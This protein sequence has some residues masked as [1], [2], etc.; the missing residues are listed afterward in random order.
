MTQARAF[1]ANRPA[2]V[3]VAPFAIFLALTVAQGAF[4]DKAAYWLYA[5]KTALAIP[6]LWLV[7]PLVKELRWSFR[8]EAAAVGVGVFVLWVGLTPFYPRFGASDSVW[9]PFAAFGE[10]SGLAW[11]LIVVR[12]AGM[13]LVV[14][15]IEEMFYRSFL[16]RYIARSDFDNM[17][18]GVMNLRA[19]LITAAIFGLAHH[20]WLP[21][22]LCG[23][24]Y[25]WLTIR[26]GRLGDA[27]TAHA[28]TNL[29]LG[30]WVVF[31]E[32]WQ[33]F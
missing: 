12:I 4:D 3:R 7:W 32:D 8:W 22:V 23:A 5:A 9:N 2:I 14:P 25:Q 27:L 21:G 33:Y 24:A 13:T 26:R 31:R 10:G 19:F 29:L 16:Y 6:M 11:A 17:S 28:I 1:L 30:L 15:P 18:L 20:H